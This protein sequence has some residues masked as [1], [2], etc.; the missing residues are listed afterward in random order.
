LFFFRHPHVPISAPV[1]TAGFARGR[2]KLDLALWTVPRPK[3][4]PLFSELPDFFL[5]SLSERVHWTYGLRVVLLAADRTEGG[6]K[7]DDLVGLVV[8]GA[9]EHA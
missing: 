2:L 1:A 3:L 4:P 5:S 7:V 6:K 8:F 9:N